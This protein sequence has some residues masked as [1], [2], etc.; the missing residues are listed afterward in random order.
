MCAG[1]CFDHV[2]GSGFVQSVGMIHIEYGVWSV[3]ALIPLSVSPGS[4]SVITDGWSDYL[5]SFY[6]KLD[7]V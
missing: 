4:F 2:F 3:R 1:W 5:T 7:P 6:D